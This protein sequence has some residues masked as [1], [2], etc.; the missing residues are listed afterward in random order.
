M[1]FKFEGELGHNNAEASKKAQK[2]NQKAVKHLEKICA[3]SS[4]DQYRDVN[5][6]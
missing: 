6:D 2:E 5:F 4:L 1:G 3:A